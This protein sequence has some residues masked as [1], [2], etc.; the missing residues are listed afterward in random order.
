MQ[1]YSLH[2]KQIS[3]AQWALWQQWLPL[4]E[5]PESMDELRLRQRVCAWGLARQKLAEELSIPP[6]QVSLSRS[7]SGAPLCPQRF[8]SLSHS[9][10]LV[11]CATADSPIGIDVQQIL[12]PSPRL[13]K[14]LSPTEQADL[15]SLPPEH[16]PRA[17]TQLWAL[18]EAW[19][20]CSGHSLGAVRQVSFRLEEGNVLCFQPGFSCSLPPV[21]SNYVLAV[22]QAE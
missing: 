3:P 7:P 6:E 5:R 14:I 16:R 8:L 13:L 11:V 15:A 22:C 19:I 21:D 18:R 10:D 9:G 17:F 4:S 2:M 12:E 1:L 20:K